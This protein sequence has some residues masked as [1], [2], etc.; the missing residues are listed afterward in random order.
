MN[1]SRKSSR[2][3]CTLALVRR[4]EAK[5]L[6]TIVNYDLC[7]LHA[8]ADSCA[9]LLLLL[10]LL[11]SSERAG[12]ASRRVEGYIFHRHSTTPCARRTT[13]CGIPSPR[14]TYKAQE[15]YI[16]CKISSKPFSLIGGWDGEEEASSCCCFEGRRSS[17]SFVRAYTE[18]TRV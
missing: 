15:L 18:Q 3:Y 11:P 14:V 13:L 17:S 4:G 12:L 7:C 16:Y 9:S 6:Y 10:L 8:A 1:E 5:K 2:A